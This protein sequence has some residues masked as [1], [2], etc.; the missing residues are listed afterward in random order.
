MINGRNIF[1]DAGSDTYVSY[2]DDFDTLGI[3]VFDLMHN[4]E[5]DTYFLKNNGQ[6]R[7]NVEKILYD[8]NFEVAVKPVVTKEGTS[9]GSNTTLRVKNVNSD[10]SQGYRD[11]VGVSSVPVVFSG[12]IFSNLFSWE[13]NKA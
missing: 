9:Y 2:V 4:S 7:S 5:S 6:F 8:N 3:G 10:F 13:E 12:G 1:L 11:A